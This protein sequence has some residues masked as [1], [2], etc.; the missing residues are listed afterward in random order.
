MFEF[1]FLYPWA[2]ISLIPLAL[3]VLWIKLRPRQ[4]S[5]IAP[6]IAKAIG[7]ENRQHQSQLLSGITLFWLLATLALAG[8]SWEH[9]KRP[10]YQ[11]GQARVLVMDM[12]LS[13]YATDLKPNRLTQARYKA[14]D[15]LKQWREGSTGLIAYAADAYTI[16]P[17]TSDTQTIVNQIPNLSPDI[18]PYPGANAGQGVKLAIEMLKN[19]GLERGDIVLMTDDLDSQEVND[20]QQL[21]SNERWQLSILG[22][23]TES[24][25]PIVQQDGSLLKDN[26]NSTVIAKANFANMGHLAQSVNGIFVPIQL[27]SKDINTITHF[28]QHLSTHAKKNQDQSVDDVVNNGYWLVLL[29]LLP[30]LGLFRRGLIFTLIWLALPLTTPNQAQAS[31]WKNQ[32]QQGYEL[33]N[34]KQY[35]QAEQTFKNPEWKGI[36]QYKAGEFEKAI[37]S[38]Q[39]IDTPR[40]Q[41]NLGN[42][43]AQAK[44]FQKAIDSY[45]HALKTQP[46]NQDAQHNLEIVKKALE[47]Q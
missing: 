33:F 30:A 45:K 31:A 34:A 19:A 20:I 14:M 38:L 39:G 6:H 7:I 3:V 24:G 44:Q 12:S 43:Y 18:M 29:L 13:M 22:V 5:L 10:S 21:L 1:T 35:K 17:L 37:E 23:G 25:A 8:P 9:A 47:R 15:L 4:H 32:D 42:A 26:H 41:Y 16:S 36:A 2:L 46:N 28:T 11:S 40:A 27:D